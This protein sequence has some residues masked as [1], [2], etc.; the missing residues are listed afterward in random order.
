VLPNYGSIFLLMALS[1][2]KCDG[3][4]STYDQR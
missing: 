4:L 2:L 1:M 3:I